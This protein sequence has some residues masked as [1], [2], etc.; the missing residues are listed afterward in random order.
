MAAALA[1]A[2]TPESRIDGYVRETLSLAA[3]G[4]HRAAAA[5]A[6]AEL[7]PARRTRLAELHAEQARPLLEAVTELGV[8]PPG[9]AAELLGG[10]IQVAMRQVERG[11]PTQ[12]AAD[13][14]LALIHRGLVPSPAAS[15][16]L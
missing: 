14:A 5:L 13:R 8:T 11:M 16:P 4:A 3:A 15:G 7:P 12:E 9:P 1:G 2:T 6:G 10:L